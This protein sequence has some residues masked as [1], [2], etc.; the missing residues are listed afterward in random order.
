MKRLLAIA[1]LALAMVL[2][3]AAAGE[4][5]VWYVDGAMPASGSGT[6]WVEA[7][8]TIQEA[9]SA[10]ANGDEVWVKQ[11]TYALASTISLNKEIKVYGGFAGTEATRDGRNWATRPTILDGQNAVLC[12]S[13]NSA[14]AALD[15]FRITKGNG[16]S[17]GISLGTCGPVYCLDDAT[18]ITNCAIY[19]NYANQGGGISSNG[20]TGIISNCLVYNNTAFE[21][22][23]IYLFNGALPA[24]VNCTVYGNHGYF[25]GG[26]NHYEDTHSI[27]TNCI[28]WGNTADYGPQIYKYAS[29]SSY[30]YCDVQGGYSGAGNINSDPLL[31][32]ALNGNFHL[33]PGSPCIDA[34]TNTP[35]NFVGWNVLPEKDFDGNPRIMD[36]NHD[37]IAQVD[38]GAYEYRTPGLPSLLLLLEE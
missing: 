4:A 31:V 10:A 38:M 19:N 36:G 7:K 17:G 1:S 8:K 28:I 6:S 9:I 30:I 32:N 15:G 26:M 18:I 27:I 13:V 29:A 22:G 33:K 25:G 37:T 24:I 3:V 35:I 34:G 16:I 20:F 14:R 5:G 12:V 21:G 11:G 2:W 23:G